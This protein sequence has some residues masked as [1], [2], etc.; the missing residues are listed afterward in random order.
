MN[1]ADEFLAD[2]GFSRKK[3]RQFVIHAPAYN[4][5]QAAEQGG[6]GENTAHRYRRAFQA[7]DED[8]RSEVI[9]QLAARLKEGD[10]CPACGASGATEGGS[11]YP[12]Y[13]LNDTCCVDTFRSSPEGEQQ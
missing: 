1:A 3:V 4:R 10:Q 5:K 9:R 6:I 11:S 12:L 8:T 13:C 7:L 2:H